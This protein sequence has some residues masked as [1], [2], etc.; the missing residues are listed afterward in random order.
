MY[1]ILGPGIFMN[2]Y[3][4]VHIGLDMSYFWRRILPVVG[5]ASIVISG[6]TVV[7]HFIPVTSW[8][9]FVLRGAV[10][11]AIYLVFIL[12]L[13]LTKGERTA[14]ILKFRRL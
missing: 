12:R 2:W 10:Y 3:Y 5:A 8:A 1:V 7:A 13:V 4:H 6:C 9:G 11:T 14:I